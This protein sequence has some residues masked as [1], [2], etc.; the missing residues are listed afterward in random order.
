MG[1]NRQTR[2]YELHGGVWGRV[3]VERLILTVTTLCRCTVNC[4]L[5]Y[6]ALP[7]P[8][9]ERSPYPLNRRLQIDRASLDGF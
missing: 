6:R 7:C 4:T 8:C 5:L 1:K 9:R 2:P 3:G